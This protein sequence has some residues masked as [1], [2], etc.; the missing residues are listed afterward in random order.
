MF[1]ADNKDVDGQ[2]SSLSDLG[3]AFY[4]AGQLESALEHLRAAEETARRFIHHDLQLAIVLL[5]LGEV[6]RASNQLRES[7]AVH[8][9]AAGILR[10]LSDTQRLAQVENMLRKLRQALDREDALRAALLR[11]GWHRQDTPET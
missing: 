9:E 6:L 11:T 10:E 8:A 2:I 4:R 3:L 5:R 1:T 7:H